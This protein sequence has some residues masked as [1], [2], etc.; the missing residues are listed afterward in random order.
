MIAHPID[1]QLDLF[2]TIIFCI[3]IMKLLVVYIGIYRLKLRTNNYFWG[4]YPN[5]IKRTIPLQQ[6]I[7]MTSVHEESSL[8]SV[9]H[10]FMDIS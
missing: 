3:Q 2:R 10:V 8:A 7:C 6:S 4:T 5:T 9:K 1:R